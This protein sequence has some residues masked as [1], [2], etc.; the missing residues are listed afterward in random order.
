[1][2]RDSPPPRVD[3]GNIDVTVDKDEYNMGVAKFRNSLIGRLTLSK[4]DKPII[5][6]DLKKRLSV[7]WWIK[8]KV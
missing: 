5:N 4:S 2:L 6:E 7:I 3:G 1:M 8:D